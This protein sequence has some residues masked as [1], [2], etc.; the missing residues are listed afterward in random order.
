MNLSS[1]DWVLH[2]IKADSNFKR[3]YHNCKSKEVKYDSWNILQFYNRV[4]IRDVHCLVILHV[5]LR[6]W[7]TS[8]HISGWL[9][10]IIV[11][12]KMSNFFFPR[13]L[14]LL[15]IRPLWCLKTLGTNYQVI[16]CHTH[17]TGDLIYTAAKT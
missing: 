15:K 4:S 17:K 12:V 3:K 13:I 14:K 16:Y 8:T 11:R 7:V 2:M 6:L 10:G 5:K 9:R 1:T